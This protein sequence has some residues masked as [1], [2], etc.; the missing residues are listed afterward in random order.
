MMEEDIVGGGREGGGEGN[1]NE[2]RS[3]EKRYG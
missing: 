2:R 3:G 1:E